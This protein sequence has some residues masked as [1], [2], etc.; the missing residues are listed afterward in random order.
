MENRQHYCCMLAEYFSDAKGFKLVNCKFLSQ[1]HQRNRFRDD[2]LVNAAERVPQKL[3]TERLLFTLDL[4][5]RV[6]CIK[7]NNS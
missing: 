2:I 4:F 3:E 6:F 1:L 7:R 5:N